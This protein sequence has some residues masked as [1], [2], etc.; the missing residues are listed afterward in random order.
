MINHILSNPIFEYPTVLCLNEVANFSSNINNYSDYIWY[1]GDGQSQAGPIVSHIY[2]SSGTFSITISFVD[3]SGCSES[4]LLPKLIEVNNPIAEF[5]ILDTAGCDNLDVSFN[6]LSQ[7]SSNWIWDF[8]NEMS[9]TDRNPTI[10]FNYPGIYDISLISF[11]GACSDTAT[12]PFGVTVHESVPAE[13]SYIKQNS[14]YPV[15][16]SFQNNSASSNSIYWDFGDG[17]TDTTANP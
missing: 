1:F 4:V 5:T 16:L 11:L 14:C 13:F 6:N 12:I 8:D 10:S 2:Q 7:H 9:S 15:T 3:S 17:F